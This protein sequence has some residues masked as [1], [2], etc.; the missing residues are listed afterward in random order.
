MSD[1]NG[2]PTKEERLEKC[3]LGFHHYAPPR[4]IDGLRWCYGCGKTVHPDRFFADAVY[5]AIDKL[6]PI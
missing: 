6:G 1:D 3:K 5:E 4:G 2:Y